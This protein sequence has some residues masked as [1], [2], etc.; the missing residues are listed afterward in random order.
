MAVRY[1]GFY[2]R[3]FAFKILYQGLLLRAFMHQVWSKGAHQDLFIV[4]WTFLTQI[5]LHLGFL[6][7]KLPRRVI[8]ACHAG[9]VV[10]GLEGYEHH[11]VGAIDVDRL[12][13]VWEAAMKHGL[14]PV[15][16]SKIQ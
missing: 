4:H 16:Q 11:E 14:R 5:V 7:H 8:H 9:G 13:I 1:K 10:H 6:Q 12:D 2:F 15:S 3:T